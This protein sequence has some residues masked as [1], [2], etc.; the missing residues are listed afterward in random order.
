[1]SINQ[2]SHLPNVHTPG[3]S[4]HPSRSLQSRIDDNSIDPRAT[5]VRFVSPLARQVARRHSPR[6]RQLCTSTRERERIRR[7]C[8]V[9]DV[10]RT[11]VLSICFRSMLSLESETSKTRNDGGT[12]R[13]LCVCL[14]LFDGMRTSLQC[15]LNEANHF[16]ETQTGCE[17]EHADQTSARNLERVCS[18]SSSLS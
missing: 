8:Q 7:S 13:R 6:S 16:A 1:M 18:S 17:R 15:R 9:S 3:S 12:A 14:A 2:V 10:R 11:R 5:S 4:P